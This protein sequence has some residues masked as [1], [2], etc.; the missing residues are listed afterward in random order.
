MIKPGTR[1]NI[2]I[3]KSSGKCLE[4]EDSSLSNGARAQQ[5]DCKHQ[6]GSNW[7]VPWDTV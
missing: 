2:V 1:G 6:D 3:N 7:Y 5:W 4:I